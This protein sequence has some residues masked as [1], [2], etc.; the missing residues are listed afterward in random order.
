MEGARLGH[1]LNNP[2]FYYTFFSIIYIKKLVFL[3]S[4]LKF[5]AERIQT[6]EIL[7]SGN[8]LRG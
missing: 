5:T 2:Q 1:E 8:Q 3:L 7:V 6:D 4:F